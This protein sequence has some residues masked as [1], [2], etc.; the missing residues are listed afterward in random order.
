MNRHDRRA[1]EAKAR[2]AEIEK[3]F[4]GY[5][6]QARRAFPSISDRDLGEG[7]MR[8]QAWAAGGADGMI[9]HRPGIPAVHNA[10]DVLV[11]M[12]YGKLKFRAIVDP[13]LLRQSGVQWGQ[14]LN[15]TLAPE[16]DKR[17]ATRHFILDRLVNQHHSDGDTAG[18][19]VAAFAWL[20]AGSPAGEVFTRADC[21][22]S[23][24]HYEITDIEDDTGRRG[25]NFRGS[26]VRPTRVT[27]CSE[28]H[29]ACTDQHNRD[30]HPL[31]PIEDDDAGAA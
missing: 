12:T 6:A 22:Y 31:P 28:K 16:T 5:R 15:S 20:I 11:S 10:G 13:Q 17:G 4:A 8:G 25:Q 29:T 27:R 2:A 3:G 1:A 26:L 21:P 24:F 23:R 18:M 30:V 19:M 7:W 9:I 14:V